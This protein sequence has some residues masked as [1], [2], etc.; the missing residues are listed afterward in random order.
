MCEK[1]HSNILLVTAF[2]VKVPKN[3]RGAF[4]LKKHRNGAE[5]RADN[6]RKI[7]L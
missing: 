2:L 6:R 3:V 1:S 7:A 4:G 5:I